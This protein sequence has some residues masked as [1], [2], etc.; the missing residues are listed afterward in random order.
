MELI[1]D[2]K[3]KKH[4]LDKLKLFKVCISETVG[5][6]KLPTESHLVCTCSFSLVEKAFPNAVKIELVQDSIKILT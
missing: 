1:T 3:R 6:V 4:Q 5:I 2:I